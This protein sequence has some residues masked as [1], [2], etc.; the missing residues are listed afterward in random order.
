MKSLDEFRDP[1]LARHPL[2]ESRQTTTRPW[3]VMEVCGGGRTHA[4]VR[5]GIDARPDLILADFGD[6]LSVPAPTPTC[7]RRG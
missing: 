4:L 1:L 5:Q 2:D 6:M 7:C 3:R